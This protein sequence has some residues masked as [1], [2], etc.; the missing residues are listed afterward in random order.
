M[1]THTLTMY[2]WDVVWRYDEFMA[3]TYLK[4]VAAE[5]CL[6][7]RAG[8]VLPYRYRQRLELDLP[9]MLSSPK[10]LCLF[11]GVFYS[12]P[13]ETRKPRLLFLIP[14][15]ATA[16]EGY[17]KLKRPLGSG[18]TCSEAAEQFPAS[19]MCYQLLRCSG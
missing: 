19:L 13:L 18:R 3:A 1:D 9:R 15:A 8:G 12:H 5:Y 14:R 10:Q 2:N 4:I 7:G 17:N 6:L 11:Q 16:P